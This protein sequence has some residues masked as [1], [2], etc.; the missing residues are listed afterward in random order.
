MWKLWGRHL[1]QRR[2]WP[3]SPSCQCHCR[4]RGS[5]LPSG[6]RLLRESVATVYTM[7]HRSPVHGNFFLFGGHRFRG[8]RGSASVFTINSSFSAFTCVLRSIIVHFSLSAAFVMQYSSLGIGLIRTI[9]S[10]EPGIGACDGGGDILVL[11]VI[12]KRRG[13][14]GGIRPGYR[15]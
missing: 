15:E 12:R 13:G 10:C 14:P 4:R 6:P 8:L 1:P 9:P 7:P 2:G 3:R 5:H 11:A